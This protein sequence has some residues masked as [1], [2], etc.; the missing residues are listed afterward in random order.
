M[1]LSHHAP[2]GAIHGVRPYR[3]VRRTTSSRPWQALWAAAGLLLLTLALRPAWAAAPDPAD[4]S[5]RSAI[6]AAL[7]RS[8]ALAAPAANARAARELAV[9]AGQRPDPVL[10]LS[11]NNVPV[12]G[13]DRWSTTNDFM[14]MQSVGI[15][16]TLPSQAKRHARSQK[17]ER[18]A[19][20]SLEQRQML[21]TE[22]QRETAV[23]WFELRAVELKVRLL[24]AQIDE[25][26]RQ[27]LATQTAFR[28]GRGSQ[29][30]GIA[31][32]EAVSRLEQALL[33]MQADQASALSALSRWTGLASGIAMNDPL[34]I[35]SSSLDTQPFSTALDQHI[36]LRAMQARVEAARAN[37]EVMRL[38][39]E[40]DWSV[41]LMLSKRG[42][43]YSD[44][45][46]VGL[47]V[48]LTWDRP[49]RQ[50]RELAASL[51]QADALEA[52]LNEARRERLLDMERQH[53]NWRAA[54]AQLQ[55]IDR[56]RLPLAQ[57]R[58]EAV[59]AAYRSGTTP[60]TTVLEAR[61][62]ALM[63]ATE[64]IDIELQAARLWAAL[65]FLIPNSSPVRE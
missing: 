51:A 24:K 55:L 47:S 12:N 60:L 20:A 10:R 54:L 45:M 3:S 35:S 4:L 29:T 30:D 46:S 31:A 58:V 42:P 5:L 14:T 22:I 17:F 15:M 38:E 57:Q 7:E 2:A 9:A 33:Q 26:G 59:L 32:R 19:D 28:S 18:E 1:Y 16:Q 49:Q 61:Q 65:E 13:A 37:A 41:E 36:A 8:Q 11:L 39:R 34:P 40:P 48:P 27:V 64:R 50:D 6:T 43:Q 56:D 44:M 63:L 52:E 21:A 62:A 25:A 53:Q 23:A